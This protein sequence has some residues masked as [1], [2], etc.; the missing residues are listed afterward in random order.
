[1]L[2]N[3]STPK[4]IPL[5]FYN[6]LFSIDVFLF[7]TGIYTFLM[8]VSYFKRFFSLSKEYSHPWT[9]GF[10]KDPPD[11]SMKYKVHSGISTAILVSN[12]VMLMFAIQ[13]QLGYLSYK[14]ENVWETNFQEEYIHRLF[15]LILVIF[16]AR[17]TYL[18]LRQINSFRTASVIV[19]NFWFIWYT[20][21]STV[22]SV[23]SLSPDNFKISDYPFLLY[24]YCVLVFVGV[25]D[26]CYMFFLFPLNLIN[27]SLWVIKEGTTLNALTTIL[28]LF[29]F[30]L[31]IYAGYFGALSLENELIEVEFIW[32]NFIESLHNLNNKL[33]NK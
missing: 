11:K 15:I 29:A 4:S 31:P 23:I 22:L 1:M 30:I 14:S 26:L 24:G 20:Y 5:T 13:T 33:Q 21:S 18:N 19:F 28:T 16:V 7:G 32:S 10:R 17:T 6:F 12:I 25:L 8:L 3:I 2:S 9:D 27:F